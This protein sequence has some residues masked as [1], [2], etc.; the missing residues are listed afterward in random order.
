MVVCACGEFGLGTIFT[1]L[2]HLL[3][4]WN[5]SNYASILLI[6]LGSLY[7][8][9]TTTWTPSTTIGYDLGKAIVFC[10]VTIKC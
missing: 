3:Q 2:I 6:N 5:S 8:I 1:L 7:F 9:F 10:L 4:S